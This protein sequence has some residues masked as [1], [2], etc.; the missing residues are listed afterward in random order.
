M[1]LFRRNVIV[2]RWY[3]KKRWWL[4]IIVAGLWAYRNF[5]PEGAVMVEQLNSLWDLL[6]W[7]GEQPA[8]P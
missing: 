1:N 5:A 8:S 3:R 4:T 6:P 7:I 2:K